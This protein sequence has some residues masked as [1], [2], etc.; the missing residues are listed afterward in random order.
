MCPKCYVHAFQCMGGT[1]TYIQVHTRLDVCTYSKRTSHGGAS[2]HLLVSVVSWDV[3]ITESLFIDRALGAVGG[4]S[5]L[6]NG[7]GGAV[8]RQRYQSQPHHRENE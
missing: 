2:Y 5:L 6:A 1:H 8:D 3:S 7:G 4:G